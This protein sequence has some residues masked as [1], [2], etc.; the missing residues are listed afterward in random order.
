MTFTTHSLAYVFLSQDIFQAISAR[1]AVHYF[2]RRSEVASPAASPA[3][4][5]AERVEGGHDTSLLV[6]QIASDYGAL[7]IFLHRVFIKNP[8]SIFTLD[9]VFI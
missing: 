2:C 1:T 5:S 9:G 4:S 7:N 6:M 8:S 3:Q